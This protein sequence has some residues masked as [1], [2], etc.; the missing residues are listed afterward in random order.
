[1]K[2]RI[3]ALLA[4]AL[5]LVLLVPAAVSA[6]GGLSVTG[7]T[8]TVNFPA[9]IVF[10]VNARSDVNITDI[11]LHYTVERM[12]HVKIVSE[13]FITF[14]P[15]KTVAAQWM[16]DMRKT[17]GFPPGTS[18]DY[19]W[20]LTDAGG[21]TLET[22]PQRVNIMDERYDWQ[23]LQEGLITLYW[24]EGDGAFAAELMDATQQALGRL[25]ENTG[26]EIQNPVSIYIYANSTD[27][28]GS[29]IY[30][31]EWTGGVAFTQYSVIA[32]G[33]ATDASSLAWGKGAISHELTHL[34]V[35]QVT[36]N[37]YNGL[38][39]WLD[40]GLAM[41]SEGPLAVYFSTALFTALQNDTLLSVRSLTSPFS[42]YGDL[43]ILSYAESFE[44]VS[45]LIS[46]YGRDKMLELLNI[47]SEGSGY[48]EALTEV[49]GFDMDGLNARW[50]TVLTGVAAN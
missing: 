8:A 39:T 25:S 30:P 45:Y 46:E 49:Y 1:M 4:I 22:V 32:I 18:L 41:Y 34:V 17:G 20:T 35:H 28:Q 47:F 9:S 15:A 37:P 36:F 6:S 40:E 38:P 21:K 27:L 33:I 48:D 42:A 13:I 19:W 29:M 43:S 44:F 31:Q 23:S 24:Y 16:M 26:A 3:F 50:Q 2:K 5:V 12:E 14:T 7:S 11:R 10:T